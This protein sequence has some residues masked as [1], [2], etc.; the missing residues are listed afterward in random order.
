MITAFGHKVNITEILLKLA[1]STNESI[2][3]SINRNSKR[4]IRREEFVLAK[5]KLH[6]IVEHWCL[7]PT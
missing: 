2:S 6:G 3:Q 7:T 5:K 4:N 1:L